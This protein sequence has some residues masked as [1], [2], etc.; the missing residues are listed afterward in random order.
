MTRIAAITLTGL[1]VFSGSAILQPADAVWASVPSAGAP[2]P[3]L[4]SEEDLALVVGGLGSMGTEECLATLGS[5]S[6][7]LKI[8]G[9]WLASIPTPHSGLV[10][11]VT[12]GLGV[13]AGAAMAAC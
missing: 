9:G 13:V 2:A 6:V 12:I 3:E 10:G 5:L 8:G 1:L 4:L 11:L 7:G